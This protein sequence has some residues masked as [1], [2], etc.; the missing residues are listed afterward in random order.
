MLIIA[1]T[2]EFNGGSTFI[3][4]F[5]RESLNKGE[6]LGVLVLTNKPEVKLLHEIERYADVYFLSDFMNPVF[7]YFDKTPLVGFLP[8]NIS[9]L[10]GIFNK[11]G[12]KAHVMAVFGLLWLCRFVKLTGRSVQVSVGVYHQN[13]FMFSGAEY[14]FAKEGQ[15]LF[16]QL[17]Q[18]GAVFYNEANIEAYTRFFNLDFSRASLVPIG[19]E[20]PS[21]MGKFTLGD[22]GARRIVSIGNLLN[23]KS[24]NS[25]IINCMPLLLSIDPAFRYEIYGEG[26][27]DTELRELAA[28]RGVTEVVEFR[29]RIP[30][31]QFSSV[32]EGAF[33]FVGSGTAI[34][35]AAAVGVPALIGIESTKEAITYGFLSDIEGFSYNELEDG[36]P[37]FEMADKIKEILL[38]E[39]VWNTVAA[40]CK[41]KAKTFSIT[42]TVDGF[43]SHASRLPLMDRDVVAEYSNLHASI[44]L[45]FCSV[46]HKLGVNRVFADRRNQGT[47]R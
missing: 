40:S 11:H 9:A 47:I 15:R 17:G 31:S 13:E 32:L 14:Y 12:N 8:F 10:A 34:I 35:E 29:G 2:L 30:Y 22:A 1:N 44:S 26:P 16:K 5:S 3:L 20:L 28:K 36:R 41:N 25:H 19:I 23:F 45:F 38:D 42:N 43:R 37:L 7:Q 6:R 21:F 4:R 33:L 24:Y 39:A 18:D 27:Y 46:M